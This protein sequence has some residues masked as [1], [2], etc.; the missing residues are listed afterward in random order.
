MFK[1]VL[2][3]TII[4]C[5]AFCFTAA[6]ISCAAVERIK[7]DEAIKD[8]EG[9]TANKE[10]LSFINSKMVHTTPKDVDS[11][12][13]YTNKKYLNEIIEFDAIF[14]FVGNTIWQGIMI[15][16]SNPQFLPWNWQENKNYLVVVT[17]NQLELQ[18]FNFNSDYLAV[19]PTPFKAG[20][21][22]NIQFGAINVEDGV[23]IVFKVNGKT[24]F[25]V[26]D[27][28]DAAVK[29]A[30]HFGVFNQSEFTLLPSTRDNL[31]DEPSAVNPSLQGEGIVGETLEAQYTFSDFNNSKEGKSEFAW[32]R[33]LSPI[34][35]F[36]YGKKTLYPSDF[37]ENHIEK[38]EGANKKTYQLTQDD[39]GFYVFCGVKP[40]TA[41]TNITGNEIFTNTVYIDNTKNILANGVYYLKD[42]PYAIACGQRVMIDKN[43]K[44]FVP[45][46]VSRELYIPLRFTAESLGCNVDWNGKTRTCTISK[47]GEIKKI[48]KADELITKF[49]SL[50]MPISMAEEIFGIK[51]GYEPLYNL[52]V[53]SDFSA[54]LN[55]IDYKVLLRNIK[56]TVIN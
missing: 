35:S 40:K 21:R 20:E 49:D 29:D 4:L 42:S 33:T 45:F 24:I 38:I 14:Q 41:G 22:V 26:I 16:S 11:V 53:I 30:G 12:F 7:L 37:K 56:N 5:I 32:Y 8:P 28:S 3:L 55:P 1:R 10:E 13:G 46:T 25:N 44:N 51:S 2:A 34:D 43:N 27:T 23:Q 15:R 50:F 54:G 36:G 31:K 6:H 52:G 47:D 39:I 19:A 9:W 18:R 48:L 17:E